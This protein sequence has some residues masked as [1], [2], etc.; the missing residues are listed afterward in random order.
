MSK[1]EAPN[2]VLVRALSALQGSRLIVWPWLKDGAITYARW[3]QAC[4]EIDESIAEL[5]AI[6]VDD[7]PIPASAL[8]E[9]SRAFVPLSEESIRE[10]GEML[11][12]HVATSA[13]TVTRYLAND[14]YADIPNLNIGIRILH[15]VSEVVRYAEVAALLMALAEQEAEIARLTAL[16]AERPA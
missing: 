2:D 16:L 10:T 11:R 8:D 9:A 4:R 6:V 15:G 14:I 1:S 12:N 5:L 7:S 13:R 3:E